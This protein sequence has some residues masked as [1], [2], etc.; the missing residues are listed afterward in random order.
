MASSVAPVRMPV[1]GW[2]PGALR[3]MATGDGLLVRVR[4]PGGRL[5]AATAQAVDRVARAFGNGAIDLTRRAN[6]QIRGVTDA[7]LPP[8]LDHL[9]ALGLL[10]PNGA[11]AEAVRNVIGPP[12]AGVDPGAWDDVRAAVTALETRLSTDAVLHALPAKFGVV[13]D[14]GGATP[15]DG[16]DGD[17]VFR[18]IGG[19]RFV[20]GLDG[21]ADPIGTTD[22]PAAALGAIGRAFLTIRGA[23]RRVRDL[24]PQDV[25]ALAHAAGPFARPV[26]WGD[27]PRGLP[28]GAVRLGLPLG[29]ADLAHLANLAETHADGI[30][31]LSPW[32][33]VFLAGVRDPAA[34]GA[35]A[36]TLITDPNDPRAR[37]VA[38]PGAPAC[39]S[40]HAA[41]AADALA[42]ADALPAGLTLHV[43]GCPKGCA[44]GRARHAVVLVGR[45]DGGYDLV[46]DGRA[47]DPPVARIPDRAA[48]FTHLAGLPAHV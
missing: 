44:A 42:L 16:V 13:V 6:L 7:T 32:R 8:L 5:D 25:L 4:V 9:D 12:L 21:V 40:A 3:P 1:K 46:R 10:E 22:D 43:S 11:A 2:C 34:L 20:V 47:Q 37:V 23:A 27:R 33:A 29:R 39:A 24:A 18:A 15:M 41:A 45:A 48:A 31:R 35:L 30:L 19:G 38:C 28:A 17:V 26:P 14:D 36:R